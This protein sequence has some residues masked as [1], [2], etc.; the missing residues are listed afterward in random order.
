MSQRVD[1]DRDLLVSTEGGHSARELD[2]EAVRE[3]MIR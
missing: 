2:R 1:S 3:L